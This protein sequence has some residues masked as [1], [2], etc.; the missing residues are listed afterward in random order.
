M[1]VETWQSKLHV[2]ATVA[3]LARTAALLVVFSLNAVCVAAEAGPVVRT[4]AGK[5]VGVSQGATEAFLGIP[6][7]KPPVGA[8]RWRAPARLAHWKGTRD[9]T[10]FAA[11]CY[12]GMVGKAFGPWTPEF[13]VSFPVSEDCLYLNVWT[14]VRHAKPLPVFVWIHGGGF[15]SGSGA[16]PI[17]NGSNLAA[18]GA[19]VVN[20]NYRV[21][22]FGFMAHPELSRESGN[23][24]SGNYGLLDMIAALQWVH[25]N[26]AAFGGDARNVTIG[27]QS[28]GAAA[29]NDLMMSPLAKGLF[30]H[31]VAESG[32]GMGV[33]LPVLAEAEAGGVEFMRKA[34][35]ASVAEL[36]SMSVEKINDVAV[37]LFMA[38]MADHKMPAIS[39]APT[40]DNH[41]LTGDAGDPAAQP[42]NPVPVL[43]GYNADEGE[44][45]L[46]V[47]RTPN[48]FEA[49][50][51]ARYGG[52]AERFLAVYPHASE[53][54]ASSSANAI[55]RDRYMAS[56][57]S[58][59][60]QRSATAG[61]PVFVYLFDH[62]Y[63][64]QGK[65]QFGAFHTSEVP[66]VFGVL[67]QGGR[68]FTAEDHEISARIQD[69]W[70]NF[71][72]AGD[73]NGAGLAKWSPAGADNDQVM[74]LGDHVGPR[75]AVSTSERLG[76][77]TE[78]LAHKGKLSLF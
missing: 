33:G 63:P 17:Y 75:A 23:G 10:R 48:E 50:V 49:A 12:Q 13:I 38:A 40:L 37:G 44:V 59:A 2:G 32:S 29:V 76:V 43:T 73:P 11:S 64:G 71:M 26:I 27:G 20:M 34:G 5:V 46:G 42:V 57:L 35:A 69:Y 25:D 30:V 1:V 56:A 53:Q 54:E 41:V 70:L 28:A 47:T 52:D 19:V 21:G 15:G 78:Y 74:G 62:A 51:R 67:D 9:A 60:K 24:V 65:E 22:V 68:P 6:F 58:W 45:A 14:P 3:R 77:F 72:R 4:T 61:K 16:I 55:A 66:Y 39:F 31:G 36:R 7:A 8:L 18:R